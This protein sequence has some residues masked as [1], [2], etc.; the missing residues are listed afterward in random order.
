MCLNK[1]MFEEK[2]S[3]L[4]PTA[5]LAFIGAEAYYKYY[6]VKGENIVAITSGANMNFDRLRLAV[7]ATLLPEGPGSFKQFYEV[8]GH[9]NITEFLHRYNPHKEKA[10]VLYNV[11]LHTVFELSAIV[12]RME[13]SQLTTFNLTNDD[14]NE[15]LYWFVFP[16]R[17]DTL[18]SLFHYREQGET[19]ANVL[20]GI[21]VPETEMTEFKRR[22][23][24][25]RYEHAVETSNKAYLLL[26]H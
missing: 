16:E 3:I 6:G 7:L 18:M 5:A 15:L 25:L 13:S 10:L 2:R 4:E 26:I 19:G 1:N 23:D 20:V 17:P 8:V 22:V 9:M 24:A 14:L 12:K 11:G 21:Q